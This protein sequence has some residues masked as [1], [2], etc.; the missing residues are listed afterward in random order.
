MRN[1]LSAFEW[2]DAKLNGKFDQKIRG[3]TSFVGI[4]KVD[5]VFRIIRDINFI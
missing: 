4:I 5:T 1:K 3:V 2:F